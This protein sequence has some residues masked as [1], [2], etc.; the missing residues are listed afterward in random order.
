[1]GQRVGVSDSDIHWALDH[2]ILCRWSPSDPLVASASG[3]R[4]IKLWDP[5]TGI[6]AQN[7]TAH[8]SSVLSVA[9][10]P[11]GTQLAS[12]SLDG[13]LKVWD[14]SSGDLQAS[15]RDQGG[16]TYSVSWSPDGSR[17][18]FA[19]GEMVEVWSQCP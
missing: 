19:S 4:T 3:D 17:L 13:T 1:M 14:V 16:A 7:L 12:G 6:V 15:L 2:H 11:D 5:T 8:T 10:S 18:A 9:F